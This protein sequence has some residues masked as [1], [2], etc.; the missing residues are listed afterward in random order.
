MCV[1]WAIGTGY[2]PMRAAV[3]PRA[4]AEVHLTTAQ[5]SA[6]VKVDAPGPFELAVSGHFKN[7]GASD[8][9]ATYTIKA[10][11]GGGSDEVSGSLKRANVR[12][13]V[14]RRGGTTTQLMER[15]EQSH[16]IG[17]VRGGQVTLTAD[18][19][20]DQLE[21]GLLVAVRPG[22]P[23]PLYFTLLG[24]LAV[25]LALVLDARLSDP[26]AALAPKSKAKGKTYLTASA[27]VALVFSLRYQEAVT[28]H[29]LVRPAID[30]LALGL[31]VG[32]AG[33]WLLGVIAR[34]L[35]GPKIKKARA[36]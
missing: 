36:R 9:E 2:P 23:D 27:G 3:P 21:E 4:L 24:V 25:L 6:N 33:G 11:G 35:F 16:R 29:S 14:G 28:P 31:I 10:E 34:A 17:H 19:V 13:R 8:A 5:P 18:G 32:G 1:A 12:V 15:T 30:A 7:A 22:G 20:D 26:A